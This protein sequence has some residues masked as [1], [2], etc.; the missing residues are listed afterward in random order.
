MKISRWFIL[1]VFLL[2]IIMQTA[3]AH[4]QTLIPNQ[5]IV[6]S[7]DQG[8]IDLKMTFT[9]PMER[10]PLMNMGEPLQFGVRTPTGK[11]SLLDSL[12]S[13]SIGGMTGYS[14]EYSLQVPGDHTFFIEPAPYWEPSESKMIIHYTKVVVNGFGLEQGW[15]EPVGLPV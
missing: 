7:A 15:D 10:G 6:V 14:A 5:S 13:S 9:D 8:S 11:R 2:L 3:Q 12:V 1:M 4:F